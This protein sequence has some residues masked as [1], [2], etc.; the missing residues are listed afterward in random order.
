MCIGV[1][2]RLLDSYIRYITLIP[3]VSTLFMIMYSPELYTSKSNYNDVKL[4][5]SLSTFIFIHSFIIIVNFFYSIFRIPLF[6]VYHCSNQRRVDC[7]DRRSKACPS[8]S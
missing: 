8:L 5:I 3:F 7:Y 4:S 1:L 2:S 6:V